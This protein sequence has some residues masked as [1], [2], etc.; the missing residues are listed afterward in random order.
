L[1]HLAHLS[2]FIQNKKAPIQNGTFRLNIYTAT[3]S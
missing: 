1:T 3:F 2:H